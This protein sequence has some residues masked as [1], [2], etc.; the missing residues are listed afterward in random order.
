MRLITVFAIRCYTTVPH[1]TNHGLCYS[2]YTT[3]P[4]ETDD[5][6]CYSLLHNSTTRDWS[7]S[8]LFAITQQYHTRMIRV[9]AIRC[10]TTVPH[11]TDH[12]LCYSLLHNS[13]TLDWSR[14]LLFLLHNSTTWDWSRSLLFLL[15]NSTTWDWSRPLLFSFTQ[16]YHMRLITVFAFRYCT[17]VPHETDHGLCYSLLHNSTTWD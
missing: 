15:H 3:V 13:T 10:Y 14:S 9:F 6:L 5:G 1:E 12:G 16:Q 7:R 4:H 17:T 11:E 8:L 2:Y